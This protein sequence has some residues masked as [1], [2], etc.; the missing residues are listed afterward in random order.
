MAD[1]KVEVRLNGPL[2]VYGE[3]EIVDADGKN[4]TVPEG[5]WVTFCRCGQSGSRI[6]SIDTLL[7]STTRNLT[8]ST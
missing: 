4:Y 6:V 5:Q 8:R 2:R 3:I 7:N 1:A